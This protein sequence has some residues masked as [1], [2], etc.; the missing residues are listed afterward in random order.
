MS[1]GSR[2]MDSRKEKKLSR[3]ELGKMVGTSSA[4][5]G[6]YERD[7]MKPSIEIST[8]IAQALDVSLDFLVGNASLIVKDKGLLDRIEDI[9]KM[10]ADKKKE[11]LNVIDAYLRDF[12]TQQAYK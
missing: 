8:K 5:I 2:M 10:P 6:R 4:I 3:E 12:K 9:V 7:D 11:L 1:F